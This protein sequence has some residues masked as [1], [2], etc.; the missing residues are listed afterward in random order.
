VTIKIYSFPLITPAF[1]SKNKNGWPRGANVINRYSGRQR[2]ASM[3]AVK[4]SLGYTEAAV[5]LLVSA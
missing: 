3:C 4:V 1:H 5:E 2:S